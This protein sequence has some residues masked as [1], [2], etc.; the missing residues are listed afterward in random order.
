MTLS[1]GTVSSADRLTN[2]LVGLFY[3]AAAACCG[4]LTV[5]VLLR[6]LSG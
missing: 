3:G 1:G 2:L 6:L 4:A 5:F